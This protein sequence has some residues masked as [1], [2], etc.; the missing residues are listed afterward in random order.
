[1]AG[2][3]ASVK[4]T[5]PNSLAPLICLSGRASTPGWSMSMSIIDRP[6]CRS[7]PGSVRTI[8]KILSPCMAFVV[9]I[10]WPLTT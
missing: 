6:L 9:Q 4:K 10:F 1:M 8:V 5:S 3:R 7:E 2:T